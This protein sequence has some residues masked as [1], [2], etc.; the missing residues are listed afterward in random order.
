[1]AAGGS[2]QDAEALGPV[3]DAIS[4]YSGLVESARANN[5]QGYPVG[6][7]YLRQ[8]TSVLQVEVLPALEVATADNVQRVSGA[9]GDSDDADTS[10]WSIAVIALFALV[11]V[12]LW[13][14]RRTRRLINPGLVLATV[15]LVAGMVVTGAAMALA[16]SDVNDVR[17]G[18]S[19][20]SQ[21]LAEARSAA[22]SAKSDE[23]LTLIQRG[24]GGDLE[25]RA[26]AR[27]DAARTALVGLAG[28]GAGALDSLDAYDSVHGQI[29]ALDDGG[30]WDGAVAL[31]TTADDNGS[32]AAFGRFDVVSQEALDRA[33][34]AVDNDLHDARVPLGF[35]WAV[36]LAAGLVAAMAA[37]R[38]IA[39]RLREY[40]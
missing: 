27:L 18:A 2:R 8:A 21:L 15:I 3:N 17:S 23:S 35:A 39:L 6:V 29:R 25:V 14:F 28:S 32:N 12:Q 26:R 22:F 20:D 31:A 9:F 13:L 33:A 34:G 10:L 30:D 7:A 24:S 11:L 40:A 19:Q 5:R 1:M 38:G 16:Q 4:R 37:W 36:V